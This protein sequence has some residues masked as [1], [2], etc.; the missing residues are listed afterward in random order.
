MAYDFDIIAK[1]KS[2]ESHLKPSEKKV[3]TLILE[4]LQWAG[5]ASIAQ[6]AE[7]AG[8]SEATITRFAKVVGCKD[9]RDLKAKLVSSFAVGRRFIE[10]YSEKIN[11]KSTFG[12]IV[13]GIQDAL[14][15]VSNQISERA[16]KKAGT[17]IDK[18]NK[19]VV[20]GS[21]GGSTIA[22]LEAQHRLFRLGLA[23]TAHHDTI[24]QRMMA[25]TL[26]TESVVLA[27]STSG[28]ISEINDNVLTAKQYGAKVI[29]ITRSNTSLANLSDVHL[30][31]HVQESEG[32]F[33]PTPSRYALL[34]AVDTIAL[35]VAN[36][37]QDKC[38]EILRKIK[39]SIDHQRDKTQWLPL[40][41]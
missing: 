8:V 16:V 10:G 19:L 11:Q 7:N 24:M 35:E 12:H 23:V 21:G 29:S 1:I 38:K 33:K 9:V 37:R 32:I 28:E 18:C 26:D 5:N 36:V 40:G 3:V 13:Q 6:L 15:S 20:F 25:A 34:A 39:Y 31:V 14:S 4:D 2:L 22:A 17:L 27:I 41:D 30:Q